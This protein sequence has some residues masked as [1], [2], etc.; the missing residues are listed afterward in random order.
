ML[1]GYVQA[2]L[3]QQARGPTVG[4][5]ILANR[6]TPELREWLCQQVNED[7][8]VADLQELSENSGPE[9]EAFLPDLE[10]IVHDRERTNR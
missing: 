1:E 9:P 8:P 2:L 7:E 5:E 10:Q 4:Q 6:L 3:E